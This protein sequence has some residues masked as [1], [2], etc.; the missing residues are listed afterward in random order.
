LVN[1][2]LGT[3]TGTGNVVLG[4]GPT[5][6][7]P[8]ILT[9]ILDTNGNIILGLL[10]VASAINYLQIQN[11]ATGQAVSLTAQGTDPNIIMSLAGKGT[12]GAQIQ[13][14]SGGGNGS[15]GY[16][17]EFISSQIL[18]ASAV[19]FTSTIVK[20]LTS[21]SLTAGDWDVVGNIAYSGTTITNCNIWISL[22]SASGP[23]ASLAT[24]ISPLA[25]S[26][27]VALNAPTLRVNVTSTTTV[28][29]SGNVTGTG[30]LTACGG[31]QARRR[32]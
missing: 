26:T 8:K 25:T 18:I 28:Y 2:G 32:R 20:D 19:T 21:I 22:S 3:P 23:D 31:I 30:T 29:I 27:R 16:V 4:T 6:T 10:P 15:P 17:G 13:G 9:S 14:I 24:S 11:G 7:S 5:I 1:L 12:G